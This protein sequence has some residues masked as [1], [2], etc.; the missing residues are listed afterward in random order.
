M[1]SAPAGFLR[2]PI[3][4]SQDGR[5]GRMPVGLSVGRNSFGL[6]RRTI[7]FLNA[8]PPVANTTPRGRCYFTNRESES[9]ETSIHSAQLDFDSVAVLTNSGLLYHPRTG[10]N[11]RIPSAHTHR[12]SH[13]GSEL[14][15]FLAEYV[16]F[17]K[18]GSFIRTNLPLLLQKCSKMWFH[19]RHQQICS[20]HFLH[21]LLIGSLVKI[22][23][24]LLL[25]ITA[26][27]E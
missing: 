25:S 26:R 14:S 8:T 19:Y 3:R 6:G 22:G 9:E 16:I 11:R 4:S 15:Y 20:S 10:S 5:Y 27:S 1:R 24:V 12:L 18:S 2:D 21:E 17:R 7:R 13:V 23:C